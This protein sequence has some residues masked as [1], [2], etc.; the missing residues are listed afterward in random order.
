MITEFSV[1]LGGMRFGEGQL[2]VRFRV[3]AGR[4]I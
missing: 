1:G 3:S 2:D 4:E